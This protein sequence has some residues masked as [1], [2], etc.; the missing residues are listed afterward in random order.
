M[1][2]ILY[3]DSI[4]SLI[5][6]KEAIDLFIND[7]DHSDEY[8]YLEYLTIDS[9]LSPLAVILSDNSHVTDKLALFSEDHERSFV[10]FE[11]S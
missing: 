10:F 4:K 5:E 1:E 3:G 11:K 9:K 6:M 8:E 2:K 7:S